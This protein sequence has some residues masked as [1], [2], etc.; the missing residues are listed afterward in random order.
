MDFKNRVIAEKSSLTAAELKV[1]D[2]ILKNPRVAMA[3]SISQLAVRAGVSAATVTRMIKKLDIDS[4][5]AMKV[6]LSGDLASEDKH[7]ESQLDIRANESFTS[8]CNKLIENE[9]TNIKQTKDLLKHKNCNLVINRLLETR[10]IYVFGVGASALAAQNIY[11]KWSRIGANVVLGQDINIF[12][13][14][15]INATK[16]DTLWLISN[17]G[18]TPE[19]LYLANYAKK[20]SILTVTLTKFGHNS[21]YKLADLPLTTCKPI[22]PDVRVG[23]TNSITGQFYVID[24]LFYLYFS[25]DFDRCYEAIKNSQSSVKDYKAHFKNK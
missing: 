18:E 1:A 5:T 8:I 15:L 24:V 23:A 25:R 13:A 11:Q 14:Q 17:S 2:Y 4:Y 19:V 10:T 22:E 3:S 21:L 6:M 12:L 16:E 9:M 20:N 7:L